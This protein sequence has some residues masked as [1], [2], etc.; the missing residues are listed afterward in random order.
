MRSRECGAG[1]KAGL[2]KHRAN[3][4]IPPPEGGFEEKKINALSLFPRRETPGLEKRD[5]AVKRLG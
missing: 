2:E 1:S 4:Q 5:L 3:G